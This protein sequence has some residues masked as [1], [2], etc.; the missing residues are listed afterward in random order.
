MKTE[1]RE[2][3]GRLIKSVVIQKRRGGYRW[4]VYLVKNWKGMGGAIYPLDLYDTRQEAMDDFR[5]VAL[6]GWI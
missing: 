2:F 5:Q 4:K 1:I 3:E 6:H